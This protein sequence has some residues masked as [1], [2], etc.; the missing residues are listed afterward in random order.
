MKQIVVLCHKVSTKQGKLIKGTIAE[1]T[2]V[3]A[4][5]I[6]S[7]RPDAIEILGDVEVVKPKEVTRHAPARKFNKAVPKG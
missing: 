3:E 4:M 5:R 7:V 2:E 1:M 6:L